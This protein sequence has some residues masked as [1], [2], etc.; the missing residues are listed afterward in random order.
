M[1]PVDVAGL[2]GVALILVAYAGAALGKVDPERPLSLCCN[3]IGACL[4]LWS[5]LAGD[6][7]LSATVME[8]AWALVALAGLLRWAL[9]RKAEG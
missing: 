3:L 7:N 4:I 5:L 6:F 2:V 1:S 8:G 9:R